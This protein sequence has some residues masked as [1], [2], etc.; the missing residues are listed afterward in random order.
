VSCIQ[1]PAT[2][3]IAGNVAHSDVTFTRAGTDSIA[4]T[5]ATVTVIELDGTEHAVTP[6]VDIDDT[7]GTVNVVGDWPIPDDHP[8]GRV[9]VRTAVTGPLV[10]VR[11]DAFMVVAQT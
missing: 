1:A 7:A 11:E 10:G 2:E 9:V 8:G 3:I 5:T 4:G 6:V